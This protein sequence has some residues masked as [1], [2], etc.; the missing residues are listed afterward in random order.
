MALDLKQIR[1]V[2]EV[3]LIFNIKVILW[4]IWG[5]SMI[6]TILTGQARSLNKSIT[7]PILI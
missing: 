3:E 7:L 4:K 1:F 2:G 5:C 6:N